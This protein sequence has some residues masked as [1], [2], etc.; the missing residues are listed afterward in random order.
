MDGQN[1]EGTNPN[2]SSCAGLI[3]HGV[4][5]VKSSGGHRFVP[6]RVSSSRAFDQGTIHQRHGASFDLSLLSA[7]ALSSRSFLL[8]PPDL[9]PTT[10]S[11]LLPWF[12]L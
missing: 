1:H 5:L 9:A 8:H 6:E 12:T 2:H 3:L 10:S 4:A 11:P 7:G